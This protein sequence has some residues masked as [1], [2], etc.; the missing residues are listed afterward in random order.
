MCSC[1]LIQAQDRAQDEPCFAPN[2]L[3]NLLKPNASPLPLAFP[4][5]RNRVDAALSMLS[6]SHMG[7]GE[8]KANYISKETYSSHCQE[9]PGKK[10]VEQR[11]TSNVQQCQGKKPRRWPEQPAFV[12]P[13]LP[14]GCA[15]LGTRASLEAA[16]FSLRIFR[17]FCA[18]LYDSKNSNCQIS[19]V[20]AILPC[21]SWGYARFQMKRSDL[22]RL[23][24]ADLAQ[25]DCCGQPCRSDRDSS[26]LT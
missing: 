11:S 10:K 2:M 17:P 20:L 7:C 4:P 8:T 5:R 24:L 19:L 22:S 26:L 13:S 21:F 25:T 12:S 3:C 9:F 6:V 23:D 18:Y 14:N 1:S 16:T 15:V